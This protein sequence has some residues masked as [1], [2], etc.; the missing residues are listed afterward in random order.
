MDGLERFPRDADD[1]LVLKMDW[2]VWE[3]KFPRPETK[4]RNVVDFK[5][6]DPEEVWSMS[7]EEISDYLDWFQETQIDKNQRCRYSILTAALGET[8]KSQTRLN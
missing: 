2:A 5:N 4:Q 1:P 6:L 3:A 7:K 8:N